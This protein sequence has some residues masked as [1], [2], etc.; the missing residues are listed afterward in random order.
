[1]SQ[2]TE[3]PAAVGKAQA[4]LLPDAPKMAAMNVNFHYG[5]AQALFDVSL[6]FP[7]KQVTA[8]I[9]PSGCG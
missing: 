6:S 8:L 7:E 5:S 2:A 1:M 4:A 3:S 9:G